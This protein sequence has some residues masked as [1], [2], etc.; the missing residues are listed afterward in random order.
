MKWGITTSILLL[1]I[2]AIPTI[3]AMRITITPLIVIASAPDSSMCKC[4]L[5]HLLEG[6]IIHPYICRVNSFIDPDTSD[7]QRCV[8]YI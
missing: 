5:A 7:D 3:M 6:V 2:S 4:R 8:S 1:P